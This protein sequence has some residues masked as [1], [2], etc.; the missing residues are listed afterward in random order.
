MTVLLFG[1][2]PYLEYKENPS[3]IIVKS[4]DGR[5]IAGNRIKGITL[6]VE[7]ARL[8]ALLVT[9]LDREKPSL[10][11]GLGLAPGRNMITPEKIAVN[12]KYAVEPDNTGRVI[13]G[14]KIDYSQ[15]DG[16]FAMLPVEALVEE[17]NRR[18]IPASL[19]LSAGA[20][21]CNNAMFLIVREARRSGFEGGFIHIPYHAEYVSRLKKDL[22]SLPLETIQKGIETSIEFLVNRPVPK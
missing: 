6:P 10:A 1:F 8:E 11:I 21:L 13:Q 19:S 9:S 17:L 18:G 7:Y 14:E 16:L 3:Q 15:P 4:L 20:F 12:Y 2:E 5:E 22:P